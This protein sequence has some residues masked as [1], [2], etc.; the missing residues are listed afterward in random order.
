MFVNNKFRFQHVH[1]HFLTGALYNWVLEL[2]AP[3]DESRH[4]CLSVIFAHV[5]TS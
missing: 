4:I 3:G 2:S 1:L 5:L